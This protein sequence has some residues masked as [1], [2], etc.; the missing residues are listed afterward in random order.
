LARI[1]TVSSKGQPD[2][3]PVVF[4]F[5]GKYFWVGS[6]G[7][8]A[9][10]HKNVLNGNKLIA[11]TIDDVESFNPWKGRA[12]RVYGTAEIV[13]HRGLLGQGKYLRVTPKTS[14]SFGMEG[15]KTDRPMGIVKTVHQ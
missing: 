7:E 1:A 4:E 3:V 12:V 11:L 6:H 13:D 8:R 9:R 15:L 14:W 10:K 5:D 2:V